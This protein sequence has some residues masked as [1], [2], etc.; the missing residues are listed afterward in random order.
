MAVKI[1]KGVWFVSLVATL[2]VLM[3]VYASLPE[4]IQLQEEGV[5]Q[6][7]SR[8]QLFYS[9]LALLGLTNAMVFGIRRIAPSQ[10]QHF[11]A[12]FY[13]LVVSLNLFLVVS[14]QFLSLYNSQ[15]KFDYESIGYIIYGSIALVVM[16]STLWPLNKL[17]RRM[18]PKQSLPEAINE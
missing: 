5:V 4:N 9:I 2:L 6:A 8:N 13:G 7:V 17:A 10:D 16:W 14:L 12:W 1:F 15:E 11:H 18:W 3:Y